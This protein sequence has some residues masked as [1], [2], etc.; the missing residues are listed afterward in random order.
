MGDV[1]DDGHPDL[2][3]GSSFAGSVRILSGSTGSELLFVRGESDNEGFGEKARDVGDLD[4]DGTNDF[5]VTSLPP[6]GCKEPP[7][8]GVVRIYSGRSG[9]L[10][11][12]I[13]DPSFTQRNQ[14]WPA[15]DFVSVGDIDEDGVPD[16]AVWSPKEHDTTV[17]FV[18]GKDGSIIRRR[19]DRACVLYITSVGD[20]DG[21][22][23]FD[24]GLVDYSGWI[25]DSG[26]GARE[27]FAFP[28]ESVGAGIGDL[29]HDGHADLLVVSNV[30]IGNNP[31][32]SAEWKDAWR[33]GNLD[34]VSGRDG[35]VLLRID[36]SNLDL[37]R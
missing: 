30:V 2:L 22:G 31:S 25:I 9:K 17:L 34:V 28:G 32:R 27:L 23:A 29:D 21:D 14:F 7:P 20:I 13:G 3:L 8:K 6:L 1:D 24:L 15:V 11:R 36:G 4:G 16:M 19:N 33:K 12:T 10:I 26:V 18:S 37:R 35:S 5:A